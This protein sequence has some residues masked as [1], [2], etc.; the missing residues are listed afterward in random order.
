MDIIFCWANS[1]IVCLCDI[2][3]F[4]FTEE[5]GRP[6]PDSGREE[7]DRVGERLPGPSIQQVQP[8]TVK[9]CTSPVSPG[10]LSET[11]IGADERYEVNKVTIELGPNYGSW[12]LY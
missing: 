9:V 5:G 7:G 6:W 3:R 12:L 2:R 11:E 4:C 8:M 1:H 10:M